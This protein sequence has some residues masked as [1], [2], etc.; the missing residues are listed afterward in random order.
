[1]QLIGFLLCF[2]AMRA[3]DVEPSVRGTHM[4]VL[5]DWRSILLHIF[6][7]C[8]IGSESISLYSNTHREFITVASNRPRYHYTIKNAD[9]IGSQMC[10]REYEK[11]FQNT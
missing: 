4:Q 2:L 3:K 11:L 9:A 10:T 8:L 5:L 6:N 7:G 1:M